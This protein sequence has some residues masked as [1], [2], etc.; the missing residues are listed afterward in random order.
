MRWNLATAASSFGALAFFLAACGGA[1]TPAAPA[2][3]KT[4]PKTAGQS[5]PQAGASPAASPAPTTAGKATGQPITFGLICDRSGPTAAAVSYL[6]DGHEDWFDFVNNVQGGVKG[7]PLV[8]SEI[9]AKYEVPV[10]VDAYKKMTTRDN[11]RMIVAWGTPLTDALAPAAAEDH[12]PLWNPG[13]LSS[14]ADGK[15]FPFVFGGFPVYQTQAMAVMQFIADEWKAQGKAGAPKVIYLYADNPAGLDPL[16]VIKQRSKEMGLDL[17]DTTPVP[18]TTV[19]TST[20]MAQIKDKNPDYVMANLFGRLPT[21]ALQGAEKVGFPREKMIGFVWAISEDEI[22]LAGP[23][24]ETYRGIQFAAHPNDNPR[25]YQ[26]LEAY[27]KDSGK[28]PNPRARASL[29]YARGMAVGNLF[30]ETARL[31]DNPTDGDSLKKGAEAMK[32][33]TATGLLPGTTITPDDH[34]GTGKVRMYQVK[35]GTLVRVRDWFEG[36]KP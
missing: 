10:A 32:D 35:D 1:A 21:F 5:A 27:W 9:D 18:L 20:I 29:H 8:A 28:T 12:V 31:A 24:T 36:P 14:S 2:T 7:R 19:D 22:K 30:A 6:C 23:G 34:A 26:L 33:F 13:G 25:A 15:K 16:N 17:I 3:P 11:I 4:E